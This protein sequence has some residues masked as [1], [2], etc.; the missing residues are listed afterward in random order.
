M[1]IPSFKFVRPLGVPAGTVK[2]V[3]SRGWEDGSS[4]LGCK[5][6]NWLIWLRSTDLGSRITSS[7]E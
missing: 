2:M 5:L 6:A 1:R 3:I 7:S 4:M